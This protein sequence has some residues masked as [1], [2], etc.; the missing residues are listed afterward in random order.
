M[1]WLLIIMLA[2]TDLGPNGFYGSKVEFNNFE[3][4]IDAAAKMKEA[5]P[6]TD[7]ICAPR[8]LTGDIRKP[9]KVM[10]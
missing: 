9:R 7:V 1:K 2:S 3:D 8:N 4:C 6:K 10:M 5:N